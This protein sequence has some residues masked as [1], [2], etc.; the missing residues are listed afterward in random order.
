[1]SGCKRKTLDARVELRHERGE[2]TGEAVNR[3][4]REPSPKSGEQ[5][6]K[7]KE[8]RQGEEKELFPLICRRQEEKSEYE[9]PR[10]G[11]SDGKC[12][13]IKNPT[14]ASMQD[15]LLRRY[16]VDISWEHGAFFD[17]GDTEEASRDTLEADG[18]ATVRG[19]SRTHAQHRR[20]Y[21][22]ASWESR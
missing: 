22:V 20:W 21:C 1:M 19:Q 13:P 9:E 7:S 16:A 8:Q 6:E 14:Y 18:E 3:L 12:F 2:S 11:G 10:H 15:F 4:H 17:V 5:R